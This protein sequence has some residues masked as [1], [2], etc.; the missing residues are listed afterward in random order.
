[1][2][3]DF[4][5]L[6]PFWLTEFWNRLLTACLLMP[7]IRAYSLAGDYIHKYS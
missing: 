4:S 1:M 3:K 5:R 6:K 7:L 2:G